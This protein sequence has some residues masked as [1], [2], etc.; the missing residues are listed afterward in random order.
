MFQKKKKKKKKNNQPNKQTPKEERG[1][2]TCKAMSGQERVNKLEG[3]P[4]TLAERAV[5][6]RSQIVL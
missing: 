1:Y 5:I 2:Y 4:R 6:T 3:M